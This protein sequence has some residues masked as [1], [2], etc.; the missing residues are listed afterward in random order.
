MKKFPEYKGMTPDRR[1]IN[2]NTWRWDYVYINKNAEKNAK[3]LETLNKN[4]LTFEQRIKKYEDIL[5]ECCSKIGM[6]LGKSIEFSSF[7]IN[8]PEYDNIKTIESLRKRFEKSLEVI[9]TYKEKLNEYVSEKN[10]VLDEGTEY[11]IIISSNDI[12]GAYDIR[13]YV[14]MHPEMFKKN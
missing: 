9:N 7:D 3:R 14:Q 4:I 10:D 5:L 8:N 6:A 2:P 11:E 12:V 13:A 1:Q